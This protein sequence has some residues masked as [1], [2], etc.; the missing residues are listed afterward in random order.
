MKEHMPVKNPNL[1]K[2]SIWK[3]DLTIVLFRITFPVKYWACSQLQ[4]YSYTSQVPE[5]NQSCPR[6]PER[7]VPLEISLERITTCKSLSM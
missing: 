4:E 5:V 1:Q 3:Q 6:T 7:P 2:A